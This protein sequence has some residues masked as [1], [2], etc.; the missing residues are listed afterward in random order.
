M[1]LAD[2]FSGF[3]RS[4]AAGRTRQQRRSL[5]RRRR[6]E[7]RSPLSPESLEARALLAVVVPG[8]EITQDWGSG[9][10]A[11]MTLEN[12]DTQAVANWTVSFDYSG[13]I[14]SIWDATV[15]DRDGDRYT[16]ANAGWNGSLDPGRS[17]PSQSRKGPA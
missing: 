13:E 7:A 1:S 15:V 10:Q 3:V 14:G 17:V 2:R 11:A 12:R 16:V 4:S 5:D 6:R 9:F 8:Y